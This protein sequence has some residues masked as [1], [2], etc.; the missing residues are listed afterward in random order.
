MSMLSLK[1]LHLYVATFQ[2]HLAMTYI[3]VKLI[4]YSR[5]CDFYQNVRERRLL[6]TEK[7][8]NQ[9]FPVDK[10]KLHFESITIAIIT[11]LSVTEYIRCLSRCVTFV[12]VTIPSTTPPFM[13]YRVLAKVT[14][15]VPLVEKE[16][17]IPA[18]H[19]CF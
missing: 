7:L 12:V 14:Q 15:Q 16:L 10:I 2:H 9:A 4:R 11:W 18:D 8:Q 1:A 6:L 17:H 13:T 19:M 3:T 5:A